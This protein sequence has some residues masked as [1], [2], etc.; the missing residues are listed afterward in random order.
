MD[1]SIEGC[2]GEPFRM[3]V[4]LGKIMEF[5]RA[6][7]SENPSYQGSPGDRPVVPGTFLMSSTFWQRPENDPL[8]GVALNW[9]RVLHGRQEFV[10]HGCP[11]RAGDV[12]TGQARIERVYSKA[13]RRGGTMTFAEQV[14]E[15]HDDSG[16]L[17]AE[18]RSTLIETSK[19]AS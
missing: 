8:H 18:A 3:V 10:F 13:G 11:P 7:R 1:T 9:H 6:T 15:F 5:A 16:V 17:V 14:T 19:A 4:E 2:T 12:L